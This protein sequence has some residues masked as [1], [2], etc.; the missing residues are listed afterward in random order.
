MSSYTLEIFIHPGCMG[1]LISF[2]VTV[3]KHLDKKKFREKGF[4]WLL[5]PRYSPS[6]P[7]KAEQQEFEP[8]VHMVPIVRKQPWVH[9]ATQRHSPLG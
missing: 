8:A 9:G 2:S 6:W 5:G 1:I 4:I 7:G 3:I